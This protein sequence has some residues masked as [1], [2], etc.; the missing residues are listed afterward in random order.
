MSGSDLRRA[1]L[2]S[3]H[4]VLSIVAAFACLSFVFVCGSSLLFMMWIWVKYLCMHLFLSIAR[5]L[6][7]NLMNREKCSLE[8]DEA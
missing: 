7:W 5:S 2:R 4:V 3:F 6:Y 8:V 1:K